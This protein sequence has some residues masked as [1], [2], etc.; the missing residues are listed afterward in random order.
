LT[1][2]G[3]AVATLMLWKTIWR[4]G[5]ALAEAGQEG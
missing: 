2:D 1:F 3:D 4:L 5:E